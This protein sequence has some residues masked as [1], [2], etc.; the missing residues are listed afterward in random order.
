MDGYSFQSDNVQINQQPDSI[1]LFIPTQPHYVP[2][3]TNTFAVPQYYS[4]I[5]IDPRTHFTPAS[6]QT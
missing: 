1:D 2:N 6:T 4:K 5:D 3:I